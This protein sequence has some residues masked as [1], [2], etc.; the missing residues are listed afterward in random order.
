MK[1]KLIYILLLSLA[2]LG[3]T[4]VYAEGSEVRFEGGAENFVFISESEEGDTDLFSN[5][6][7]VM[8]GDVLSEQITVTNFASE[9]DYVK[10]YLKTEPH[11]ETNNP[12]ETDIKETETVASMADFLAQLNMKVLQGDRVVFDNSLGQIE[13]QEK[14]ILL[15]QF[16]KGESTGLDLTLSVPMEL[17]N[18][19]MHRGGEVDWVF[20][21]EGFMNGEEDEPE[22]VPGAADTG[23]LTIFGASAR[24]AAITTVAAVIVIFSIVGIAYLI[25]RKNR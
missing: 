18:E 12:L 8:P 17:G 23:A 19:Y 7:N 10:I 22:D 11:N 25:R 9:Y 15:G 20:V 21:A 16:A 5:L 2:F 4:D 14:T 1:R 13:G 24:G 6:K 3:V